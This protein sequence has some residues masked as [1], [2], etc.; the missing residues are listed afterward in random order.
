MGYIGVKGGTA[1]PIGRVID[2][3]VK[4]LHMEALGFEWAESSSSYP[5]LS[6]TVLLSTNAPLRERSSAAAQPSSVTTSASA[7]LFLRHNAEIVLLVP[8][9]AFAL[10]SL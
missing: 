7:G 3:F 9:S 1:D 4:Q 2:A 8:W 10:R 6:K 5:G